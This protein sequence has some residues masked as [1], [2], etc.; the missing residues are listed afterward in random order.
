MSTT[1][2][3]ETKMQSM[4]IAEDTA[5]AGTRKK[6]LD[7]YL[8]ESE[9][10]RNRWDLVK[11][12]VAN[13]GVTRHQIESFNRFLN[14]DINE[15]VKYHGEFMARLTDSR[16]VVVRLFNATVEK[17]C[18]VD[19]DD[20]HVIPVHPMTARTRSLSYAGTVYVDIQEMETN[21]E[22]GEVISQKIH[23]RIPIASIPIMLGSSHCHLSSLSKRE[24]VATG[25]CENDPMGYF[26]LRGME[27]VII[28]QVR[29]NYNSVYCFGHESTK[30]RY[31]MVAEMRSMNSHNGKSI[32][33]K[34][35]V[36][37]NRRDLFAIF[38]QFKDPV[39][40]GIIFKAMGIEKPSEYLHIPAH[41]TNST[42]HRLIGWLDRSAKICKD[43]D[44]AVKYIARYTNHLVSADKK[45]EYV[46]KVFAEQLFPHLGFINPEETAEIGELSNVYVLAGFIRKLILTFTGFRQPDDRDHIR[47][48]RMETTGILFKDLFKVLFRKYMYTVRSHIE[49]NKVRTEVKNVFVRTNTITAG[50]LH[51]C[52]TGNWGTTYIRTGVSQVLPRI[53]YVATLTQLRSLT[54]PIGKEGKNTKIRQIHSSQFG[55]ICPSATPE[56]ATVG[57]VLNLSLMTII[58]Q[59][60]PAR[61]LKKLICS[62]DEVSPIQEINSTSSPARTHVKL[63][64]VIIGCTR[65]PEELVDKLRTMRLGRLI[66][67]SVSIYYDALDEEV[68]IYSDEGRLLRPLFT[69]NTEGNRPQFYLESPAVTDWEEAVRKGLV[70][71]LAP[72]EIEYSVIAMDSSS[73]DR[74]VSDYAE[75]HPSLLLSIMGSIV[76]FANHSQAPRIT[77]SCAMRKQSIGMYALNHSL[78]TDVSVY[79]LDY[80]QKSL[81]RT[82]QYEMI[83]LDQ[84]PSGVNAIVAIA[85]YSGY[86][87]E[88]AIIMN[89]SAIERGMFC[90]YTYK[91][92]TDQ[93]KRNSAYFREVIQ[94]PPENSFDFRRKYR[95]YSALDPETGVIR[96]GVWVQTGDVLVGKVTHT[97]SKTNDDVVQDSSRVVKIG[98][99]GIVDRVII[100]TNAQG[101][102]LVKIIIRNRKIPEIGD[103][104]VSSCAQ[105]GICGYIMAQED[106][107][108]TDEGITPDII[109]NAHAIPSRM[110]IN[111]LMETVL[112]KSCAIEGRSR[113]NGTSF[114][115][116]PRTR[117]PSTGDYAPFKD[118]EDVVDRIC[119]ELKACSGGRY[120]YTGEEWM[121]N[122]MTGERLKSKVFIGPTFYHRLKHLVSGKIH[123][124]VKGTVTSLTRQPNSGR[125]RNGGLRSGEMETDAFK[126]GGCSR[127]LKDRLFDVSDSYYVLVCENCKMMLNG[128]RYCNTCNLSNIKKLDIPYAA[129]LL[130]QEMG[131]MGIK[132]ELE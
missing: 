92:V 53:T 88:D 126:A 91:T 123:S 109:I 119:N 8:Y 102:K 93:E 69:M 77:Y 1:N 4:T 108:F 33:V 95:D 56:G 122:G 76:N 25:E 86:N 51:H 43:S 20:R 50:I 30:D 45:V 23:N 48:K 121:T 52:T 38:P 107:P 12:G 60:I 57:I 114:T 34:F 47:N 89:K 44:T 72:C 13:Q 118:D 24:R 54:I 42:T 116:G 70:V 104:F 73:W 78:R 61:K 5:A 120:D 58:S 68:V 110:T 3:L 64:S 41:Q 128:N 74:Q 127:F 103:K 115:P 46:R 6:K 66:H 29:A 83:G 97:T 22:T 7:K 11:N 49:R 9:A 99:E 131:A 125:S 113:A 17:P 98:E 62:L 14:F 15:I 96:K 2:E 101:Y 31:D 10:D 85:C 75:I 18:T 90:G 132:V 82:H 112:G 105:K 129:K 28:T 16:R 63:N 21:P 100:T 106:M 67:Y 87:M 117:D 79:V 111:Q 59:D 124:R 80:P 27:K 55:Y 26:I 65:E 71:Y 39:S 81:V 130:F 84:M 32:S 94:V 36:W 19:G 35:V 40:L 37:Q